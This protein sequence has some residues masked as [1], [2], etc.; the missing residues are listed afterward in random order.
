MYTFYVYKKWYKPL[1]FNSYTIFTCIQHVY[2][3][4]QVMLNIDAATHFYR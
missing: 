2:F 3:A 1:I 4:K